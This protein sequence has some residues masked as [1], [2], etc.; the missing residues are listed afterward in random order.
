M[1]LPAVSKWGRSLVCGC[2][3]VCAARGFAHHPRDDKADKTQKA[4]AQASPPAA[5]PS[6]Q[7]LL[8]TA[9]GAR[10]A[11]ALTAYIDGFIAE[12]N[13]DGDA[14]LADYQ[15]VLALDPGY[16]DLAVKVSVELARRGEV[17]QGIDVLKD[18][19]KASPKD[20]MGYLYLSQIYF[21]DLKK[22]DVAMKYAMEGLELAPANFASYAAVYDIYNGSGQAKK[23]EE[24]LDR[25]SKSTVDDP[26]FW[27]GIGRLYTELLLKQDGSVTSPDG[28]KKMNAVYKKALAGSHGDL[29]TKDRVAEFYYSSRQW[30]DA[31]PL[32]QSVI[33]A[34]SESDE[35][36]VLSDRKM[37]AQCYAL[38]GRQDEAIAALKLAIKQNPLEPDTY[39]LLGEI[40]EE[41]GDMEGA[42][43]NFQQTL[44]LNP[45]VWEHY[46]TVAE[47]EA[48]LEAVRQSHRDPGR[49]PR[50]VSRA[51]GTNL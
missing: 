45:T 20:P 46:R 27:L 31:I 2:L 7:D 6:G 32:F 1:G 26:Q 33:A 25:A 14:M 4:R 42:L 37:L 16:T 3:L 9:E 18:A 50:Q 49:S 5:A 29:D 35:A 15:K 24:I 48:Q 23:A 51:P 40:Y 38:N 30:K 13:A 44:L 19:I 47:L 10:K 28:L 36:S 11:D 34:R 21:K 12:D 22:A 39:A 41:K 43:A 8:L 17:A